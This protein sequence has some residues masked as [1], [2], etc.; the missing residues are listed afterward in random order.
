MS[1]ELKHWLLHTAERARIYFDNQTRGRGSLNGPYDDVSIG[2]SLTAVLV[3]IA[4]EE[5]LQQDRNAIHRQEC[6]R[7]MV[8]R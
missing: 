5:A 1:P 8:K 6:E 3:E 2:R 4:H 7:D